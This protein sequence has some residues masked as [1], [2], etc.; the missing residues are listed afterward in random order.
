MKFRTLAY[1]LLALGTLAVS[2]VPV[3]ASSYFDQHTPV[4]QKQFL[5]KKPSLRQKPQVLKKATTIKPFQA[6][7][8]S[9]APPHTG[10][11][12]TEFDGNG[13]YYS[14]TTRLEKRGQLVVAIL[15]VSFRETKPDTS[16]FAGRYEQI[17]LDVD[18]QFPGYQLVSVDTNLFDQITGTDR[19]HNDEI[20][21]RPGTFVREY[22]VRGDSDGGAFGGNDEP[23]VTVAF[24]SVNLSLRPK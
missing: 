12:D 22:V 7:T 14:I 2:S 18:Q 17:V 21:A 5:L 13:P 15:D 4:L 8:I 6:A 16:T 9:Y 10:V 24:S 19:G 1:S 3:L 20:I 11:G 23:R